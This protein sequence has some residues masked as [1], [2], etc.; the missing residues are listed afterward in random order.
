MSNYNECD[1]KAKEKASRQNTGGPQELIK[2]N[3]WHT[4]IVS[5]GFL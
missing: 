3:Y 4:L 1:G 5:C 2:F